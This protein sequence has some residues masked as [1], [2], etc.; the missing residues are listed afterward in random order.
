M[1]RAFQDKVAQLQEGVAAQLAQMQA[2]FDQRLSAMTTAMD[3]GEGRAEH[4][5]ERYDSDCFDEKYF[6]FCEKIDGTATKGDEW[7]FNLL[8]SVNGRSSECREAMEDVFQKAG[9]TE[10]L[11][12]SERIR[13]PSRGTAHS[14]SRYYARSMLSFAV[15][16]TG[17]GWCGSGAV[18]LIPTL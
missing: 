18:S 6:R 2:T 4:Q 7:K 16:T 1:A 13:S 17:V 14:C 8:T 3:A 9:M 15:S 10:D 12:P 11:A 5:E